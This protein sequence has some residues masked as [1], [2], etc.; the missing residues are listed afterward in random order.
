MAHVYHWKHGWIP[1]DHAAALSKAK[2]NHDLA[3]KYH[4]D[5]HSAG[6]GIHSKRDVAGAIR[7][8]PNVPSGERDH[9]RTQTQAAALKHDAVDLLPGHMKP[10]QQPASS[11][12]YTQDEMDQAYAAVLRRHP[13]LTGEVLDRKAR[14]V[15]AIMRH[16]QDGSRWT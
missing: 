12:R 1:L 10:K 5:A 3:A 11:P 2:G 6:A 16:S 9:A 14:R 8:L 13:E 4:A 15:A 7:D